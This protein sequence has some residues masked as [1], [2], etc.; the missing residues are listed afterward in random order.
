MVNVYTTGEGSKYWFDDFQRFHRTDGPARI[1]ADG[2]QIWYIHG[3]EHREDGPSS[4]YASG[5]V[6]WWL[7]G[8]GYSFEKWLKANTEISGERKVMLKLQYG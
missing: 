7:N 4:M 3:K 2:T 5:I 6:E 1:W 8:K